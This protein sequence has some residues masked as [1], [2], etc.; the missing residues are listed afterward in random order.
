MDSRG[1]CALLVAKY[2]EL[3]ID[4]DINLKSPGQQFVDWGFFAFSLIMTHDKVLDTSDKVISHSH[5]LYF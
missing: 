2:N 4:N 3:S 1:V 5:R